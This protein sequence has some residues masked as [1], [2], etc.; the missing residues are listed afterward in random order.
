MAHITTYLLVSGLNEDDTPETHPVLEESGF[1]VDTRFCENSESCT[2][3]RFSVQQP[4]EENE[5]KEET[6]TEISNAFPE[7][8]VTLAVVEHRFGQIEHVQTTV[9]TDGSYAG[10]IEHGLLYN[11]GARQ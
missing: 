2:A 4:I 8:T 9:F 6:A 7:S 3:V 11:V 1:E 5:P 10:E